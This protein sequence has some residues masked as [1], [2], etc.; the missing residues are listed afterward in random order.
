MLVTG[1]LVLLA[2]YGLHRSTGRRALTV[3]LAAFGV[4]VFGVGVFPGNVTP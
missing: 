3:P 1:V 2:V 4:G